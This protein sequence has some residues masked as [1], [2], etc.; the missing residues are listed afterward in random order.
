MACRRGSRSS[1]MPHVAAWSWSSGS[2]DGHLMCVVQWCKGACNGAGVC[3]GP[4]ARELARARSIGQCRAF[5]CMLIHAE[6][7]RRAVLAGI[8]SSYHHHASFHYVRELS[9]C[10]VFSPSERTLGVISCAHRICSPWATHCTGR[11]DQLTFDKFLKL[12]PACSMVSI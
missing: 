9:C 1:N 6:S 4:Y 8:C 12:L 5:S 7:L 2:V 3:N 10:I 11:R